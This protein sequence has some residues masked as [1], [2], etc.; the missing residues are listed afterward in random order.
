MGKVKAHSVVFVVF[1]WVYDNFDLRNLTCLMGTLQ[2]AYYDNS[3]YL[4]TPIKSFGM[5]LF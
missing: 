4:L 3:S 1:H 2:S 5:L